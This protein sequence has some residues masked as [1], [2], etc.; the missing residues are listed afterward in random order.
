MWIGSLDKKILFGFL[1]CLDRVAMIHGLAAPPK[2][3]S[4][5]RDGWKG[6]KFR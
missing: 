1:I 4:S 6:G 3:S 2:N 5:I